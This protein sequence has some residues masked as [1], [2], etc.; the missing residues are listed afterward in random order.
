MS[1]S[2]TKRKPTERGHGQPADEDPLDLDVTPF[3]NIMFMLILSILAMTAWTQL[4][5]L[6]DRFGQ[7]CTDGGITRATPFEPERREHDKLDLAR[8]SFTFA[9]HSS[10]A[11]RE[12]LDTV[13]SFVDV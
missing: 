11:L 13:N 3:L 2:S 12:L 9:N 10:G 1:F 4:A 6:N 5:M 8:I 7:F